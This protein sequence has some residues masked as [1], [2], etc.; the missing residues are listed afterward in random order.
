MGVLWTIHSTQPNL[1]LYS[2]VPRL[3]GIAYFSLS[4]GVNII[5]STLIVARLLMFRRMH[6]DLLPPEHAEHYLSA[7]TLVVE[8]AALYSLFAI[9]FLVSYAWNKPINQVLLGFTQAA[10]VRPLSWPSR[11]AV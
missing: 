6:M 8:S 5:L 10:Q 11:S 4:L 3:Y 9:A 2:T 1:S 7:A